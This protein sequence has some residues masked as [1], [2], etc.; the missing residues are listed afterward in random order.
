M[1]KITDK[2]LKDEEKKWRNKNKNDYI[3]LLKEF[4]RDE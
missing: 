4:E 3:E 1:I 2:S